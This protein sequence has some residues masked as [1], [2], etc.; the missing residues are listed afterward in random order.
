MAQQAPSLTRHC[1]SG[2]YYTQGPPQQRRTRSRPSGAWGCLHGGSEI[3]S[4]ISNSNCVDAPS[5]NQ[6]APS[7][8]FIRDSLAAED[9][10]AKYSGCYFHAGV[11]ATDEAMPSDALHQDA[12]GGDQGHQEPP[13]S[14][15]VTPPSSSSKRGVYD[16]SVSDQSSFQDPRHRGAETS[17][18]GVNES[19]HATVQRGPDNLR[20]NHRSGSGL[21]NHAVGSNYRVILSLLLWFVLSPSFVWGFITGGS[22]ADSTKELY[23]SSCFQLQDS[24]P[25]L[26]A[27]GQS[28][29]GPAFI[30]GKT[31]PLL[32]GRASN[33]STKARLSI[34]ARGKSM[35]SPAPPA[36]ETKRQR[37]NESEIRTIKTL[38][39]GLSDID[40][41]KRL[42]TSTRSNH[43]LSNITWMKSIKT[44]C[45]QQLTFWMWNMS[46][47]KLAVRRT[48][49]R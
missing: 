10:S 1:G 47:M 27:M 26:F 20:G 37:L 19:A 32:S 40:W 9:T 36:G 23:R 21:S 17:V 29:P 11:S 48:A 46:N 3:T 14:P 38:R 7:A 34:Y 49:E 33:T 12:N 25:S 2:A 43:L 5:S 35:P 24:K 4:K 45:K 18:G 6:R 16:T 41:I 22:R 39:D 8:F 28:S 15:T 13:S 42:I 31:K 30:A 44:S